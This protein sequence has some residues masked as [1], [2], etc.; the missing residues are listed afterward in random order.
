M[1]LTN[2]EGVELILNSS[3][4][5]A[6]RDSLNCV[7]KLGTFVEL[8]KG[9][10]QQGSLLSM[11]AFSR[12]ITFVAFDLATLSAREPENIPHVGSH[13]QAV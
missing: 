2:G 7:K 6:L 3:T 12:S 9:A 4:G 1:R 13:Y 10:I 5:E 8:G 11:A